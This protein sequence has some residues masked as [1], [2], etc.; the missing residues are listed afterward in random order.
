MLN[1][2]VLEE[3]DRAQRMRPDLGLDPDTS[4]AFDEWYVDAQARALG[5]DASEL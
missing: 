2:K 1:L 5:A 4:A 3:L